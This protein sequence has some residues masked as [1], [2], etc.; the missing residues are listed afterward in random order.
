MSEWV[1]LA[2]ENYRFGYKAAG[3]SSELVRLCEEFGMAAYIIKPVMDKNQ[4]CRNTA[5]STNSKER[6]QVSSTRVRHALSMG[7]MKYVVDLLGRRH[8]LI[9]TTGDQGAFTNSERRVSA[10][11]ACLLNLPPKDGVYENCY[12]WVDEEN[13]VSCKVVLDTTHIHL[14]FDELGPDMH[15]T[16]EGRC[17]LGVEF[18]V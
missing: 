13:P 1:S 6:G 10:S 17:H 4:D 3:D 7:D 2:G 5:L 9:L 18:G 8:R 15:L 14:E 11:K 16:S 12:L